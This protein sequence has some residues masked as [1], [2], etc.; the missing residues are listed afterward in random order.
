MRKKKAL[1]ILG[2]PDDADVAAIK[3][4]W[5]RL[6]NKHHPDKGGELEAF[7]EIREAYETA[8]KAVSFRCGICMDT[9]YEVKNYGFETIKQRCRCKRKNDK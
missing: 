4:A 1:K 8:V 6:A 7:L 5:H 3:K 9:G 2:L